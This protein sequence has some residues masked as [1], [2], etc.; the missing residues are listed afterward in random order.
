MFTR[1]IAITSSA[2]LAPATPFATAG[3][4]AAVF[5]DSQ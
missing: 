5:V 1:R 3:F 4:T 2:N